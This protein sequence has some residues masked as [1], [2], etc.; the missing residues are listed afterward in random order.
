MEAVVNRLAGKRIGVF[1]KDNAQGKSIDD[2]N[3]ASQGKLGE[4]VDITSAIATVTAP[5]DT[6]EQ[7]NHK[8]ASQLSSHLL[9]WGMDKIMSYIDSE[10]KINHYTV[11]EQIER[12]AAKN[13]DETDA[14][15]LSFWKKMKTFNEVNAILLSKKH[16]SNYPIA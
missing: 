16:L 8:Y 13:E 12:K 6:Y 5:K 4:E 3:K 1:S 9:K 11:A 2:W 7:K 10:K 15:D 14:K